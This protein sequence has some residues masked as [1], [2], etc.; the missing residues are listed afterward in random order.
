MFVYAKDREIL[1]NLDQTLELFVGAKDGT[2][3][4]LA[5]VANGSNLVMGKYETKEQAVTAL[6][7]VFREISLGK[8]VK[9]PSDNEVKAEIIATT[10]DKQYHI[11]GKKTKGHG[12]S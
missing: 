7:K 12:G 11:A 1:I 5:K 9:I 10:T 8:S 3:N 4:L 2:Y 6:S